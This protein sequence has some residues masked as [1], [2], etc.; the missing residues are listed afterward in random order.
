MSAACIAAPPEHPLPEISTFLRRGGRV[1]YTFSHL[2]RNQNA[3]GAFPRLAEFGGTMEAQHVFASMDE[4]ARYRL[5]IDAIT[6]YAVY[7]L[8]AAGYVSSWNTG[9]ERFKGYTEAEVLGKHFSI[10]YTEGDRASGLPERAMETAEREGRFEAEGWRV[11]KDGTRFWTHVIMDPIWGPNGQLIGYAKI[12]RDLTERKEAQKLLDEA[13]EAMFQTQKLEAIG[14]LTGGVAH[15]FNNLLTVIISNLELLRKRMTSDER[16]L[17]LLD[18]AMSG[19]KRGASLTQHMLAFARRQEIHAR[20][21]DI[22]T[23]VHGMRSLMAG[24]LGPNVTLSVDLP[25]NLPEVMVD[26]TQ[27]ETVLLNL[28]INGK[29]AMQDGGTIN[30]KGSQEVYQGNN[31]VCLNVI[32]TGTG[33]EPDTLARATEPFFTTKGTGK[34]TGLGLSMVQG[35]VHQWG[36]HFSIF[37]EAG[38]G[39]TVTLRLP[40]APEAS[41]TV[42]QPPLETPADNVQSAK[43]ILVVDD[44]ALVLMGTIAMLED[45]GHVPVP[46]SSGQEALEILSARSDID[47]VIT[48]HAMPKM[49]G[50]ELGEHIAE[51]WPDLPVILA[52]GYAEL[53]NAAKT[54]RPRLSKPYLQKQLSQAIDA[55]LN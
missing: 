54:T 31:Y 44:D 40:L 10:F 16:A 28:A 21:T 55:V 1:A 30:I 2:A 22:A 23:L 9:A 24:S 33:M 46:A 27:L 14:Q 13:R 38:K 17:S 49:T 5:L 29:D 48:D 32:D 18:N 51:H 37:S 34:G 42:E 15:D 6:D 50:S 20:P 3:R 19:A 43:T 12:T 41:K 36:G 35:L 47:I 52:S 4:D 53:P 25:L 8:D 39:T 7:M 45:I 26:P 11:R